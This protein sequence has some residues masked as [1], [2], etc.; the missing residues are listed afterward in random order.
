MIAFEHVTVRA[1]TFVIRDVNLEIPTG[2]YAVLMGRTG[3]GKTTLIEAA[4]GLKNVEAGRILLD[5]RDVTHLKP[6]T[7][8][9]GFVPQDAALFST[10]TVYGHLAFA[11][12]IRRWSRERID[13]RV[14]EMAKMLGIASLLERYPQGLSGGER[15][16]V[17]LGRALACR[18]GILCLDEPLSALDDETRDEMCMLLQQVQSITQVT[19]LHVT[20]HRQEV[21]RL[22]D[23]VFRINDG[24]VVRSD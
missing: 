1:G 16:R 3:S 6:G 17:A 2:R 12:R 24:V 20:H 18:P 22:A 11:L 10:T 4:C 5:G 23:M 19:I 8:G 15:Q 21:D 13:R 7:R 14:R 9:I